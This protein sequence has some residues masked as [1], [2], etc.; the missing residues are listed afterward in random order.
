MSD[1]YLKRYDE[2]RKEA[3]YGLSFRG[4]TSP[5]LI[6]RETKAPDSDEHHT[7]A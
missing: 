7:H 5:E 4:I 1:V 6:L 2:G 3:S